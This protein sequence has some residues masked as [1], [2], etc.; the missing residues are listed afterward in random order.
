MEDE[1]GYDIVILKRL[2]TLLF[3]RF[4]PQSHT[5]QLIEPTT[6]TFWVGNSV[7]RVGSRVNQY[8]VN[9]PFSL[10][11]TLLAKQLDLRKVYPPHH[12]RLL[13]ALIESNR[14]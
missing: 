2:N 12:P 10:P 1:K 8:V 3:R 4:S 6:L 14:F 9:D 5:I 13:L 11:D 7:R